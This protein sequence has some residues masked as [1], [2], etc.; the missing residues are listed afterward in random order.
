MIVKPCWK[1]MFAPIYDALKAN[2]TVEAYRLTKDLEE[3]L[4]KSITLAIKIE[5]KKGKKKNE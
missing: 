5:K 2:K 4:D 3:S 1:Q